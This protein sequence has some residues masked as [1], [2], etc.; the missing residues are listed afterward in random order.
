MQNIILFCMAIKIHLQFFFRMLLKRHALLH[1]C[2]TA[3]KALYSVGLYDVSPRSNKAPQRRW[4]LKRK[5]KSINA[6]WIGKRSGR[7]RSD[8]KAAAR[9]T[10]QGHFS[11]LRKLDVWREFYLAPTDQRMCQFSR[12]DRRVK[13]RWL[14]R[15]HIELQPHNCHPNTCSLSSV[16]PF[17]TLLME[18]NK[19]E[20]PRRMR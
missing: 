18:K 16:H 4:F 2:I 6:Q 3:R 19:H 12:T 8:M 15:K 11:P 10:S 9:R 20:C 14:P 1:N 13:C 7:C 17:Q 5:I